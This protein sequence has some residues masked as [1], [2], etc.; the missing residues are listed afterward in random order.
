MTQLE[1][2]SKNLCYYLHARQKKQADLCKYMDVSSATVSDWC[3]AKK[4]PQTKRIGDIANWLNIQVT[5]LFDD[6][7]PDESKLTIT[8]D[9]ELMNFIELLKN[10]SPE[11]KRMIYRLADTV[12]KSK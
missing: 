8:A 10:A 6:T 3:N 7:L 9:D 4:M 12:L 1:I 11:Q 2:F 5:D